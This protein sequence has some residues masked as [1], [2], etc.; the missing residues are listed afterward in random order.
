MKK[1]VILLIAAIALLSFSCNKYC[2][3]KYYVD[4]VQDKDFKN[5]FVKE[6]ELPCEDFGEVKDGVAYE[7]K[8]K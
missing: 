2:N 1:N 6:S 5:R 7:V 3:C 8:C 4:G